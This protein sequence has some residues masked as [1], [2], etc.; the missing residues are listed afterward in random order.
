M[1]KQVFLVGK[2][3]AGNASIP[4]YGIPNPYHRLDEYEDD[5][6]DYYPECDVR[7]VL[8]RYSTIR[9]KPSMLDFYFHPVYCYIF[10]EDL[11]PYYTVGDPVRV[12]TSIEIPYCDVWK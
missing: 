1:D 3:L 11:Q 5:A 12:R 9:V 4:S 7:L 8:F 10:C 6:L 2:Q